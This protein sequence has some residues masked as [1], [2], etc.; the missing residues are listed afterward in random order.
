M[1]WRRGVDQCRRGPSSLRGY[2]QRVVASH[3]RARRVGHH[4]RP[5]PAV[6]F[7]WSLQLHHTQH[8]SPHHPE[9]KAVSGIATAKKSLIR[10]Q[11]IRP[12]PKQNT[13]Q[14]VKLKTQYGQYVILYL[15]KTGK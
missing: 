9:N 11:G 4:I 14:R 5:G 1:S 7:E 6:V 3:L 8:S 13:K 2:R 12:P 15:Q 10:T